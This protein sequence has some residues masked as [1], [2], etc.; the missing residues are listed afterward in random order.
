MSQDPVH[1]RYHHDKLTFGLIYAFNENFVL[2]LSHDEVVHGKGSMLGKMPGDEWQRFAN[3]RLYYTFMYAHPGK[4]LLFMGGEFGQVAEWNHGSSLEWHLLQHPGHEG[5]RK[6]VRDLN[7]LYTATPAL[8]Q[9]DFEPRGFEWIDG[10]DAEQSIISF[11]RRGRDPRDFVVVVCNF[12][13]VVREGYRIGVPAAGFY[14]ERL[15][16]DAGD[17]AGSG[18]GNS[19]GVVASAEETHGRPYTLKLTL[20]PL[21]ALILQPEG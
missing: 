2:P 7:R 3:L 11:L 16:S 17:Y 10:S 8:Y 14:R 6:L 1:R 9:V 15:N 21:G 19:G 12:T 4:K 13:P 18:V 5:L 20:P